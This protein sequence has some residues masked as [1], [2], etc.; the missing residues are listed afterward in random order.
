MPLR[1]VI[2]GNSGSGKSHLAG[3]LSG[4]HSM[5]VVS[6]DRLFGCRADLTKKD[7]G[8]TQSRGLNKSKKKRPGWLKVFSANWPNYF[9]PARNR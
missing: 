4:I 7:L 6:L 9:Y 1:T 3:K 8:M 2:I 5:P